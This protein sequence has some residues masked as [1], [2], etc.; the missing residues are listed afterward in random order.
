MSYVTTNDGYKLHY[1]EAGSGKPL[2]LVHGWSQCAEMFKKNIPGLSK[3]YRVIALDL[4]GHGDSEKPAHGYRISRLAKDVS[5]FLAE[6][7]LEKVNLLGWSMGCSIIWSYWAMF[8]PERLEKLILVDEPPWL[9]NVPGYDQGILK[10]EE[11]ASFCDKIRDDRQAMTK[12]FVDQMVST[13]MPEVEKDWI[14]T[15]NQKMPAQYAG[16]LLFIHCSIDWRDTIPLINLPTLVIGGKKSL[17]P[18]QS[19]VWIHEHIPG[20]KLEIFED[21]GHIMFYEEPDRF[22]QMLIDFIG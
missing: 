5:D 14:A 15:V 9:L 18:W 2:V 20:S 22:N 6:L 13:D 17:V 16:D 7:K 8:G 4:R 1:E 19:Q 10:A 3:R 11:L 21:R 12:W